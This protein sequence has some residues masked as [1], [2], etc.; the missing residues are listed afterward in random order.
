[1]SNATSKKRTM[2]PW[3]SVFWPPLFLD[4]ALNGFR[5]AK[6]SWTQLHFTLVLKQNHS[7]P[8]LKVSILK[9][10]NTSNDPFMNLNNQFWLAWE[11]QVRS[12]SF[13]VLI[14]KRYLRWILRHPESTWSS[15]MPWAE[16][17][18]RFYELEESHGDR[19]S[20]PHYSITRAKSILEGETIV[21]HYF[22][23]P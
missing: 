20:E 1:M 15:L 5:L 3:L 14:M 23:Y 17:N 8:M 7:K 18:P 16:R 2:L 12:I 4:H 6:M 9:V 21:V 22:Y 13:Q 11:G 19:R 10:I